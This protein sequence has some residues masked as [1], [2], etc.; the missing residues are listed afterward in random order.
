MRIS[1]NPILTAFVTLMSISSVAFAAKKGP[2]PSMAPSASS[3]KSVDRDFLVSSALV[4]E[5]KGKMLLHLELNAADEAGIAL[6]GGV[7]GEQ[8]QLHPNDVEE[9]GNSMKVQ[10]IQ[11][12]LLISRYSEPTRLGGFF[13]TL[14]GGYHEYTAEW[15]KRPSEQESEIR[16]AAKDS[17]GYLHH[18][19]KGSGFMGSARL[20]YR[21]V[22]AEWPIAI[23]GHL[24]IKHTNSTIRDIE[25]DEAEEQ[26]MNLSYIPTDDSEKKSIRHQ[27]MTQPDFAIDFGLIF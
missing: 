10:G 23:G 5:S 3:S 4:T 2:G 17:D 6:E 24:G 8:E 13:W 16:L 21:Y 26:E 1:L 9:T 11:A 18:R 15:K 7:L 27:F 25:V 22:A 12:S 19:V 14:G 20:G